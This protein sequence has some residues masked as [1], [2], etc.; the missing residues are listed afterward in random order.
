[1]LQRFASAAMV[2]TIAIAVAALVILLAP[3]ITLRDAS[4]VLLVWCFAPC[5]WGLWAMVAPQDWVP[6]RLP[7]WGSVLGLIGGVF[8]L[9]VLNMPQRVL[10]LSFPASARVLGVLIAAAFYYGMW[11]IVAMVY[12]HLSTPAPVSSAPKSTR[13][14]A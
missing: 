13:T 8:A 12:R 11:M 10:T 6:Q 1:M 2:A 5:V 3:G 9:F 14:A 7:M 4:P